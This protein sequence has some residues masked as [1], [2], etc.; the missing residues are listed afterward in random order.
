MDPSQLSPSYIIPLGTQV[1]LKVDLPRIPAEGNCDGDNRRGAGP[2]F[3]KAGSVGRVVIVPAIHGQAYTVSFADG[4][5]VTARQEE[6]AIRRTIAPEVDLPEHSHSDYERY[7]I[8]RVV[9]GSRA[10]GL[11]REGSDRDERGVYV[12]PAEWYWS[13]RKPSEQLL[14]KLTPD[15]RIGDPNEK[16][17]GD[18]YCWW[19]VE[20]FLRL[21]LK[22]NPTALEVLYVDERYVIAC[23]DLG[24]RLREIRGSFLSR[25]L[26]QTYSGYVLSQFRKMQADVRHGGAYKPKHAMHLLRLLYAGIGALRTGQ[27]VVDAS[28]H[29]TELLVINESPPP[30]EVVHHRALE[31]VEEFQSEF[32]HSALPDSPDVREVN[33][34]LLDARRRSV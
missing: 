32:D 12:A 19:E 6:L 11:A 2:S 8:L 3:Q 1:V 17:E 18:D 24:K 16:L 23:T 20:K 4:A 28:D 25:N 33:A 9:L 29:R 7:L 26:Y 15:S 30:F 13:L 14:F 34:F 31:L 10:Y 22:A 21:A 27:I 5:R